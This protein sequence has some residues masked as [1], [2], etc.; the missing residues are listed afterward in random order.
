MGKQIFGPV[1][2][3]HGGGLASIEGVGLFQTVLDL[4]PQIIV[5]DL[6]R[7]CGCIDELVCVSGGRLSCCRSAELPSGSSPVGLIAVGQSGVQ[8]PGA[9][10]AASRSLAVNAVLDDSSAVVLSFMPG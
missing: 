10:S 3:V 4:I 7:R 9:A 1:A 8:Q 5:D 6:K 2:V